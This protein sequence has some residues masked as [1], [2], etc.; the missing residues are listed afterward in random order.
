MK[1]FFFAFILI[2]LF[3]GCAQEVNITTFEPATIDR[4]SKAKK[5][6][7]MEFQNDSVGFSSLLE[8]LVA[9]KKVYD[10]PYFTVVSRN[11]LNKILDEQKLQYSGLVDKTTAVKIGNLI[12][13]Q[14]IIS[15]NVINSS[16][17][18]SSYYATRYRCIDRKCKEVR[19]YL[20]RCEKGTYNL[21]VSIKM[22]DVEFGDIIYANTFNRTN[23]YSHCRDESG[24]LPNFGNIMNSFSNSI[25]NEFISKIS[26]TKRVMSVELLDK[27][28]IDYNDK[29]KKLLEYSLKYI[30]SARYDK[31]EQLLSELLT[32]TNDKCYVAAYDL[33]V[34]KE[35]K[36]EYKLAKQ[37]YDLADGLVLEPNEII[38]NAVNRI[39]NQLQNKEIVNKQ[40]EN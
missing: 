26:P 14:A 22:S 2:V 27:P 38:N 3:T 32:S 1:N 21:N 5:V 37:L 10:E 39:N 36:G 33:G 23:T 34:V 9:Q 8:S 30:E 40:L 20:V 19:E 6:S 31:A 17:N 7:I 11:E 29:Q 15:G 25:S 16:F 4:A 12:G 18:R 13:V 28:E 24:S 35:S